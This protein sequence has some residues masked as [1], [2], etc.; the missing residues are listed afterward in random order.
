L[1][2][3]VPKPEKAK[4]FYRKLLK[5]IICVVIS[6]DQ[7]SDAYRLFETLNIRGV[8]LSPIDLIKNHL[9]RICFKREDVDLDV[10][11]DYWGQIITNLDKENVNAIRFFRQYIMSSKHPETKEKISESK[12]YEKFKIIIDKDV[13][14]IVKYVRDIK[15]QSALYAKIC[16]AEISFFDKRHNEEINLHLQYLSDIGAVTSY[17]LL[18]RAFKELDDWKDILKIIKLIETFAIRR[19]ICEKPTGD[20]DNYYNHLAVNAFKDENPHKYI[21]EYLKQ[22]LPEDE[23]FEK[24]FR[25]GN[26]DNSSQ[27]RYILNILEERYYARGKYPSKTVNRFGVHIEHIMSRRLRKREF[28]SWLE[29]LGIDEGAHDEHVNKIG[30]LTLLEEPLNIGASNKPFQEKKKHYS[31]KETEFSMT[32]SLCNYRRWSVNQIKNRSEEMAEIGTN[33]WKF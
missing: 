32:H 21:K 27:T 8:P 7:D 29:Y 22:R 18:L 10:I 33:V 11:K 12:L 13:D 1:N 16:L 31:P 19:S 14:N 30:N 28:K 20:L 25:D 23:E 5:N 24:S 17:T 26:Y 15:N 3:S 6:V 4:T 2:N 9:F